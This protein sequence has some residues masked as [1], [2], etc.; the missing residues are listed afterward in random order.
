MKIVIHGTKGGYHIFTSER[1]PGLIDARPDYNKV[2]TIR[3]EAYA[4]NFNSNYVIL[5]KYR[6]IRDVPGEKRIGNIAFSLVI[7]NNQKLSGTDVKTLLDQ[8]ANEY[9]SRY[10]PEGENLDNVREDWAFVEV[11]TKEYESRLKPVPVDDIDVIQPGTEE[12][13]FIYYDTDEELQKYLHEPFQEEYRRY[14]QIFFVK[15]ELKDQVEN[16]LNALRH[17]PSSN[18]TGKI[19]LENPKYKL[20]FNENAKDGVKIQVLIEGLR[21]YSTKKI[22]KNSILEILYTRPYYKGEQIVGKCTEINSRYINV[23]DSAQTITIKEIDLLPETRDINFDVTDGNKYQVHGAKISCVNHNSKKDVINNQVSF[24]GE[25]LKYRWTAYGTKGDALGETE[26]IPEIQTTNVVL[27]LEKHKKVIVTA[28][29]KSNGDVINGIT[30][31]V[32]TKQ[33]P[34]GAEIEFIGDELDKTWKITVFDRYNEYNSYS[35]DFKPASSENLVYVK[36][37]K[38]QPSKGD[39]KKASSDITNTGNSVGIYP[40]RKVPILKIIRNTTFLACCGLLMIL[41]FSWLIFKDQNKIPDVTT[42]TGYQEKPKPHSGNIDEE[43]INYCKGN[44][45]FESKLKYYK[46]T[47]CKVPGPY[48]SQLAEALVIRNAIN[49]G[50]I[51]ELKE[52]DYSPAQQPLH[53]TIGSM[54]DID[55]QKIGLAMKS[56]PVSTMNLDQVADFITNIQNL[57]EIERNINSLETED[58]CDE[59]LSEIDSWKLPKIEIVSNIKNKILAR[60]GTFSRRQEDKDIP[61]ATPLPGPKTDPAN[62]RKN[63]LATSFWKLVNGGDEQKSSYDALLKNYKSKSL[64]ESDK[65]IINYLKKICANSDDFENLFI[66]GVPKLRR[67]NAKSLDELKTP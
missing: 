52:K 5:S 10:I 45:L 51:D 22:R 32:S 63:T 56:A 60:K 9:Y 55:K 26:F 37:E 59:K 61:N 24:R 47:H 62:A 53:A 65:P 14:K 36:L 17:N 1:I 18:L 46:E 66:R 16:P 48:C 29:D 33:Q 12:A 50:N 43:I 11:L 34:V 21:Y 54:N 38:K 3:Q 58:D 23:N 20:L 4:V 31:K 25:E 57:L 44:E 35:F 49:L 15:N 40:P 7:A 67:L 19:E 27:V 41:I 13:A 8:L 28:N 6:I 30:L 2:A 64:N 39:F 42:N